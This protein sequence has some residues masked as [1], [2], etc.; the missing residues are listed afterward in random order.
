MLIKSTG[1]Q[2]FLYWLF[3]I[4]CP[5]I[6]AQALITYILARRSTFCQ[7]FPGE[8]FGDDTIGGNIVILILHTLLLLSLLIVIDCGLMHFSWSNDH[9]GNFD[10]NTLDNDVLVERRRVLGQGNQENNIDHLT[11]KNL[12]KFYPRRKVLAVNHLTFGAKRGEAFGLLGY[13][14]S[15][16]N[17]SS[18]RRFIRL[19]QGAGKT[20]TF[21]MIIG[22]LRQSQGTAF[23]DGQNVQRRIRSTRHL[24]YC[25]Q[26]NCSMDF[27][28]VED[29][30]YLL[31]RLRG[32]KTAD[33]TSM[34][35]TMI[36]LFLLDPF[37]KNYI[38]QL[39]GGTQRR[40]HAAIAL[41]GKLR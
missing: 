38:H 12:V 3:N 6:N 31:A 25:P 14:V 21:R 22:E 17:F 40:L 37:R 34:V 7:T 2:K 41:I 8:R 35:Q 23:V 27:L 32:I 1:V 39:S 19:L 9:Q 13:N 29:S 24:G 10:E 5:S 33:I 26:E 16:L 18:E 36:N 28:T 30:L 20:T 15:D 11:V 4:L